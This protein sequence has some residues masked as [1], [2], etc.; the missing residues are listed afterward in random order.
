[1]RITR[2]TISNFRKLRDFNLTLNADDAS[3][4]LLINAN[5]GRGKTSLLKAFTW[6]LF[7]GQVSTEDF[8][9]SR[10][11]EL[12]DGDFDSFS[13]EFQLSIESTG[14]S[15][16]IR[17][18]REVKAA[19]NGQVAFE[20]D[21]TL[22]VTVAQAN[23]SEPVE[24]VPEPAIWIEKHLPNRFQEFILFDGEKM[25]KFFDANVK[26]AIEKAIREIAKI[27]L[28]E[29]TIG[30]LTELRVRNDQKLAKLSGS[31]AIKLQEELESKERQS[32]SLMANL[33]RIKDRNSEVKSAIRDC[34]SALKGNEE[35]EKFLA[36]NSKLREELSALDVQR[37]ASDLKLS[38]TLFSL[39]IG[40]L[41]IAR[42]RDSL[43]RHVLKAQEAGKY[44]A[45]FAPQALEGLIRNGTCICGC[46]LSASD[47]GVS[48]IQQVI[49][50]SLLAG[51]VG[52]S[53]KEM[54]Q[55]V[56]RTEA[57]LLEK[58][59]VYNEV[60]SERKRLE[61]EIKTRQKA[62]ADLEPKLD[63][64]KGN[65][66]QIS[67]AKSMISKLHHERDDLI[68]SETGLS[69]QLEEFAISI[70]NLKK[71][72]DKATASSDEATRLRA[73]S[74]FLQRVIDQ[75]NVFKNEIIEK[76]RLT[77]ESS[78]DA[79]FRRVEGAANY[80][81]VVSKDFEVLTLDSLDREADLSEGQ[82]MIKAYMF[83]VALREVIGLSFP[84]I[85][86]TPIGRMDTD[87]VDL[88]S[89][90]IGKLFSN[91]KSSQVVMMMHDNEYTPYTRKKFEALKPVEMYLEQ[92][93]EDEQSTLK[94]GINP[95]WLDK[96]AWKD[97][98]EGK[99]R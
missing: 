31:S 14:E 48:A 40:S 45:D 2:I 65:K 61:G 88:L 18:S 68:R 94:R 84:L 72:L 27:D 80:K 41:F 99:I 16:T 42:S 50:T 34:E 38:K 13:V 69:T 86:D 10:L 70:L 73:K 81:T 63:G 97:W 83:S 44:P 4:L 71:K 64:I 54:E 56:L 32:L 7:G 19:A 12:A 36:E 74:D 93:S 20:G 17:R 62:L 79:S 66:D 15:A 29:A 22:M 87:N 78:L 95:K 60:V 30:S 47:V 33:R 90:E 3:Q 51:E 26:K 91:D 49:E 82:K 46:D 39:G 53:L 92:E 43:G 59:N 75:G 89:R 5:N 11:L 23:P 98:N 25:S 58:R 67:S 6:G 28:F 1:M 85:V 21:E 52:N 55:S 8:S 77:L 35:A 37:K 96:G 9:K 76:V 57:R 24:I